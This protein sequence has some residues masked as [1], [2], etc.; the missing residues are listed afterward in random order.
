MVLYSF[1]FSY[2]FHLGTVLVQLLM[3]RQH[4]TFVILLNNKKGLY[5]SK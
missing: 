3:F 5:S 2:P 1:L 4:L